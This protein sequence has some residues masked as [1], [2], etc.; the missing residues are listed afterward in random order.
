[1]RAEKIK[2]WVASNVTL[3]HWLKGY[4]TSQLRGDAVAGISVGVILIPQSMAYALLAGVP[5]VYGLYASVVPLLIYPIFGTSRHLAVG[6][7]AIDMLVVAAGI[8]ELN[9]AGTEAYVALA[10]L[11]TFMAGIIQIAMSAARMGFIVN[12]LSKPVILG[13]T[14]AAPI[15]IAVS[16]FGS[17][18]GVDVPTA[19]HLFLVI[20]SLWDRLGNVHTTTAVLGGGSLVALVALSRLLHIKLEALIVVVISGL[21]AWLLGL[22]EEGVALVGAISGGLPNPGLPVVGL[23]DMRRLLPAALTLALIQFMNVTT[24]GRTFAS[25][26]RY[27]ILPNK[28]LF[29]IGSANL[30]GGFFRG[31]PV[32][33]SF[34]R[35][36]INE[37][38]GAKTP[39]ANVFAALLVVVSL[40]LF[41]PL[42]YY[43]PMTAL[44]AII[45]YAAVSLIDF[46]EI[47]YLFRTKE[48][49][50]YIVL[51]TFATTLLIGIQ[52]GI[53]LGIAAS[54]I[55]VLLRASRPNMAVLGHM[56]GTRHFRDIERNPEASQLP[57]L[58][59]LRV[60][61]SFSFNN[62]EYF[63]E[64]ILKK[65]E[66]ADRPIRAVIIDGFSINDLDTTAIE[67]LKLVILELDK[68]NMELYFAGLK[69]PIR[70]VMIRSGLARSLGGTNFH[71]TTHRAVRF[72]LERW[73]EEG[74]EDSLLDRYME[75]V[76]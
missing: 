43:I 56:K 64:F 69:G 18:L 15:I 49:D 46:D 9:P 72:I 53:L 41:T 65:S 2:D 39:M 73:K 71:M 76:D 1:M 66:K 34:S 31:L 33:G 36:A 6:V 22:Q 75:E 17:L 13:F 24:L 68:L 42:L 20:E 29:A 37:Q 30:M 57:G 58:L 5:P 32:S 48:R 51:F 10:V 40:F 7:V 25:K 3:F 62:A 12:L 14:A 50:G 27:S 23:D 61:A 35:S 45:I 4:S 59:I 38:S 28:E 60:D 47:R 63:K 55:A 44:G 19:G 8:T 26:H 16:Q 54:L 11:L 21:A 74:E 67:A 70:D 52:E